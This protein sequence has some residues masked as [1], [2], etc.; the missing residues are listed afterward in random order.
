MGGQRYEKNSPRF[1]ARNNSCLRCGAEFLTSSVCAYELLTTRGGVR[2]RRVVVTRLIKIMTIL[3]P[4]NVNRRRR[5]GKKKKTTGGL[6][7]VLCTA[8]I[9]RHHYPNGDASGWL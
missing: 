2:G 5:G 1:K 6:V 9:Y 3:T 7:S 8:D 4:C